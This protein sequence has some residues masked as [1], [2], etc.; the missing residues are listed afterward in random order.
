MLRARLFD[1]KVREQQEAIASDRR[2]QVGTG[3]RSEKI[4]TYN[5]PESRISDHRIKL[6]LYKLD[7]FLNGSLDE[8]IDALAL[9]E[10]TAQLAEG[11]NS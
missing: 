10:R 6:T 1:E 5:F 11:E 3:D 2:S 9:A 8:V 4:R 7:S